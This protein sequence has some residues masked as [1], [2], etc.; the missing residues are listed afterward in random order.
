[1][2]ERQRK[3]WAKRFAAELE[4]RESPLWELTHPPDEPILEDQEA[5]DDH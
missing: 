5:R 1:M 4:R 3:A 2:N